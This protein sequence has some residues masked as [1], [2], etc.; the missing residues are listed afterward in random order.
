MKLSEKVQQ[1]K[2]GKLKAVGNVVQF[3]DKIKKINKNLNFFLALTP[4]AI[5]KADQ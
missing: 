2:S 1:I 3:G 4:R 5:E